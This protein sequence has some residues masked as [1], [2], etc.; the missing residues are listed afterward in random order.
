MQGSTCQVS[1]DFSVLVENVTT[2]NQPRQ[3]RRRTSLSNRAGVLFPIRRLWRQ[4]K[5]STHLR[6]LLKSAV[7][8]SAVL[9]YLVS[10]V[11]DLSG[12]VTKRVKK[13][14]IKP[15]HINTALKCDQELNDLTK[16]AILPEVTKTLLV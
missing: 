14:I 6:I 4:L 2:P 7:Y 8:L 15:N 13:K 10:E 3:P 11:L 9:E 12:T 1:H 16:D 5:N